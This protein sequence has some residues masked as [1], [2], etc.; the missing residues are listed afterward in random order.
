MSAAILASTIRA[1]PK[2]SCLL[3][4]ELGTV[5]YSGLRDRLFSAPGTWHL[6]QCMRS[7]CRLAWLDPAPLP[8]DL[9][10]AYK[11]YYT[12]TGSATGTSALIYKACK[13]AYSTTIAIPAL[14][15]GLYQEKR[16]F[17]RM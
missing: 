4:G 16:K 6:K 10:L 2:A 8:E 12:H 1:F 3:C 15:T 13:W 14:L 7:E 17:M 11:N 5:L 9:G